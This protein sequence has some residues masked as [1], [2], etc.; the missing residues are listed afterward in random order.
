[1]N[2]VFNDILKNLTETK[3]LAADIK[4]GKV[5]GLSSMLN[6]VQDL[7][8]ILRNTVKNGNLS[9]AQLKKLEPFLK[10]VDGEI[11]KLNI[12]DANINN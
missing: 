4:G 7:P 10:Q 12:K 9:K 5:E 6:Y 1:M 3:K 2:N 8:T 11:A